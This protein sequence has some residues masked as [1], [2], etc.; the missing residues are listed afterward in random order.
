MLHKRDVIV[1]AVNSRLQKT[2]HNYGIELTRSVQEA[3]EI[4]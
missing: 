1:L 2:S 3:L 4:D